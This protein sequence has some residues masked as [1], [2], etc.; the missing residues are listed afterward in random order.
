MIP[1]K[2]KTWYYQYTDGKSVYISDEAPIKVTEAAS[3][4]RHPTKDLKI[5][6]LCFY[7]DGSTASENIIEFF[8]TYDTPEEK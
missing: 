3:S 8:S 7:V 2:P 4:W 5:C 6:G 1:L